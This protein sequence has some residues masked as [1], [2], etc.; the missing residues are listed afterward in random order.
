MAP[1]PS[2]VDPSATVPSAAGRD[3]A[4]DPPTPHRGTEPTPI[5]SEGPFHAAVVALPFPLDVGTDLRLRPLRTTDVDAVHSWRALPE[6]ARFT[7]RRP[8]DRGAT[9][10]LVEGRVA[11]RDSLHVAIERRGRTVG[12]MGGR[13]TPA[14]HLGDPSGWWQWTLAYTLHPDAWGAGVATV[15]A[16]A[17]CTHVLTHLPVRR[18]TAMCF[19]QHGASARVLAKVGFR[20]EGHSV[21]A[22]RGWDGTWWD[23]LTFALLREEFFDA[24]PD[25]G[26]PPARP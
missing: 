22:V 20:E 17:L 25:A 8:L 24:A 6:V 1:G 19:A 2:A 10:T 13:F 11:E 12:E 15:C 16:R 9:A 4:I 3:A 14:P 18:I 21:R 7:S 23:D 5:V 26:G